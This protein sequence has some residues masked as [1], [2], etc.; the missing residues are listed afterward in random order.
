MRGLSEQDRSALVD[1]FRDGIRPKDVFSFLPELKPRRSSVYRAWQNFQ[2]YGQLDVLKEVD[3]RGRPR[4]LS[5]AAIEDMLDLLASKCDFLQ[6]ELAE[7]CKIYWSVDISQQSIS[8]Y[9]SSERWSLKVK[10]HAHVARDEFKR[11]AW[12]EEIKGYFM[13]QLVFVDE[14]CVNGRTF[15]RR[16]GW[17]PVGTP[18]IDIRLKMKGTRWSLLPA[19][20]MDGPIANP[21]VIQGSVTAE[22]F[23]EWLEVALLPQMNPFPA[24]R[25]VV[26]MDNCSTHRKEVR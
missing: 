5:P 23:E 6:D 1:F 10:Q 22:V 16:Y 3:R 21:L 7:Y 18:A 2:A 24:P 8:R 17:S 12:R 4:L 15:W 19:L 14:S 26:V 13:D 25:S 9:L 11:S 20:S